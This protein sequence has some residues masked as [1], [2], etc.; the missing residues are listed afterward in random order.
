[1]LFLKRHNLDARKET[2]HAIHTQTIT[3]TS[4][5]DTFSPTCFRYNTT[6]T[7]RMDKKIRELNSHAGAFETPRATSSSSESINS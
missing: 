4:H 5:L 7:T 1:M 6:S 2:D 3:D